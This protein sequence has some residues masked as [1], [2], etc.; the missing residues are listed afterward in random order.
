LKSRRNELRKELEK[1]TLQV[2]EHEDLNSIEWFL[3]NLMMEK[4]V[5]Q[6][7]K[8]I[9]FTEMANILN[10]IADELLKYKS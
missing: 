9:T 7:N 5:N 4:E 1:A 10:K 8:A 2:P 6:K 3:Y